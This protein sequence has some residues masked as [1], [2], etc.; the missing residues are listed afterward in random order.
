MYDRLVNLAKLHKLI[1]HNVEKT[2]NDYKKRL[3]ILE[4]EIEIGNNNHD[5]IKEIKEIKESLRNLGCINK[6]QQND[7]LK[8]FNI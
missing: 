1:P 5:I 3:K 8:Q 7:Y 4:G 6:T 2:K